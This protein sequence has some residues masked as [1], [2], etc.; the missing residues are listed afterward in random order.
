MYLSADGGG[1]KL[2]LVF[3]DEDYQIVYSTSGNGVNSYFYTPTDVEREVCSAIEACV[4]QGMYIRCCT[5]SMLGGSLV[6][7][8]A[9]RKR[10]C[11]DK[12]CFLGEG[13]AGLLAGFGTA[14]GFL[15]LSGTGSDCFFAHGENKE[16]I[17]GWGMLL[18]DEG[19]GYEIGM[20][21]LRSAI[22]AFEGRSEHTLLLDLLLERW[23]LT[24]IDFFRELCSRVYCSPASRSVIASFAQVVC[25]A[26]CHKDAVAIG[27]YK[28]AGHAMALQMNALI[29][30]VQ[31]KDCDLIGLPV[32]ISGGA[33][34]GSAHMFNAFCCDV[35]E[36]HP[37][38]NISWPRFDAVVGG[39][40]HCAQQDG[41]NISEC[42]EALK[43]SCAGYRFAI[44]ADN[45]EV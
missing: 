33:W 9:L 40:I 8:Q 26:A 16:V 27:I 35:T 14:E 24:K 4:P 1:S 19:S 44:P 31:I 5:A 29:S 3:V 6:F 43:K 39:I 22:Y 10:A 45:L 20:N 18:G 38:M 21:G 41:R 30:R 37:E 42:L 7:E 2:R 36:C 13:D 32:T 11:V 25:E 34:K 28:N 17:G 12:I 23:N 15:A